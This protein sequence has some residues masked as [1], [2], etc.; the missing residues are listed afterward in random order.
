MVGV[1]LGT[2]AGRAW[3]EEAMDRAGPDLGGAPRCYG[4]T[5]SESPK[6]A[7]LGAG[8][9]RVR[10]VGF[11]RGSGYAGLTTDCQIGCMRGYFIAASPRFTAGRDSDIGDPKNCSLNFSTARLSLLP[12]IQ[13]Q[14]AAASFDSPHPT[15]LIESQPHQ[16][17]TEDGYMYLRY[18]YDPAIDALGR[19]L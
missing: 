19:K 17:W 4:P 18:S 11:Y 14:S 1:R 12:K 16:K 9:D 5:A 3:V 6:L 15:P 2:R 13:S 10:N 7:V 8:A